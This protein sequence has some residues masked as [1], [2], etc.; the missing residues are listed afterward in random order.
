MGR[1][2]PVLRVQEQ[3]FL[4]F[5]WHLPSLRA[6]TVWHDVHIFYLLLKLFHFPPPLFLLQMTPKWIGLGVIM[7]SIFCPSFVWPGVECKARS[8]FEISVLLYTVY[9][10][11]V[12]R[13]IS[14]VAANK[15]VLTTAFFISIPDTTLIFSPS[16]P[17]GESI[18]K[19]RLRPSPENGCCKRKWI[20]TSPTGHFRA[21]PRKFGPK[22]RR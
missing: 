16:S 9:C 17:R 18:C 3:V 5:R 4:G 12:G 22:N 2:G 6:C 20:I 14:Y 8:L 7:S 11:A 19:F 13:K 1:A 15:W 21:P 10:S